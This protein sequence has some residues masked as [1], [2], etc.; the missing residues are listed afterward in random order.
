MLLGL[1]LLHGL[2]L[3]AALV[4]LLHDGSAGQDAGQDT[5]GKGIVDDADADVVDVKG[6]EIKTDCAGDVD[7]GLEIASVGGDV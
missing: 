6:A 2:L 4:W 7:N 5:I 1:V 3:A